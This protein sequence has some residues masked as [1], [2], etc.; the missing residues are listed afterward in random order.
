MTFIESQIDKLECIID[1]LPDAPNKQLLMQP[2]WNAH[3]QVK[4]IEGLASAARVHL[5]Y[6]LQQTCKEIERCW[7]NC[8]RDSVALSDSRRLAR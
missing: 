4:K 3:G 1:Q 7:P 6:V 5:Q 2:V 8:R